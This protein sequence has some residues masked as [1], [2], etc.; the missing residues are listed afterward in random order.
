MQSTILSWVHHIITV[1]LNPHQ[2]LGLGTGSK[3]DV[4]ASCHQKYFSEEGLVPERSFIISFEIVSDYISSSGW[5][6]THSADQVSTECLDT[7]SCLCLP[8]AGI[9]GIYHF[10]WP[11]K[12]IHLFNTFLF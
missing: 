1:L 5:P 3:K 6:G 12:C 9:I 4:S 10:S 7:V 2:T 11:H 8:S